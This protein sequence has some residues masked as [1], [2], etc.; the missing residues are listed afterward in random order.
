MNKTNQKL[1]LLSH[2]VIET[3]NQ[4]LG[5]QDSFKEAKSINKNKTKKLQ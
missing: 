4:T 1:I 2:Q 3:I 5:G